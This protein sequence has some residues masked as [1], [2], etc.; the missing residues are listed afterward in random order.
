MIW[1]FFSVIGYIGI[2]NTR[3]YFYIM[4]YS[5][6]NSLLPTCLISACLPQSHAHL[7]SSVTLERSLSIPRTKTKTLGPREFYFASSAAWNALPVHLRDPELSLNSFKTKLNFSWL[8]LGYIYHLICSSCT[9]TRYFYKLARAS[10][11][12]ELNW[13]ELKWEIFAK[14]FYYTKMTKNSI[15]YTIY[16][17]ISW[18][19]VKNLVFLLLLSYA[20]ALLCQSS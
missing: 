19:L 11:C 9:P 4:I 8:H 3:L 16:L 6:K 14:E 5:K 2:S 10:V 12:I 1:F 7:R 20:K 13:I 15:E 17:Q 18:L